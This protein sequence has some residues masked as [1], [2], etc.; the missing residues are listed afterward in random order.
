MIVV[1]E[2]IRII[3]G[4]VEWLEVFFIVVVKILIGLSMVLIINF[5]Y[6]GFSK[7]C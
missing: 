3:M 2:W 5:F 7:V 4:L 1:N 6:R